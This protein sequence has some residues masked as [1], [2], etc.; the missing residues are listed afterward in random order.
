MT[1]LRKSI[2]LFHTV[3]YLKFIQIY[4]RVYYIFRRRLRK[5]FKFHYPLTLST[6]SYPL[7]L[8]ASIFNKSSVYIDGKNKI[9]SLLNINHTFVDC[10]DWDYSENGKLWLYNLAYF[11]YLQNNEIIQ[12]SC[13]EIMHDF[14]DNSQDTQ[15]AFDPYPISVRTVNWIKFI[16][17]NYIRDKKIDASLRAQYFILLDN[18]EY[19]LL[20]NHLLE[21]GFSLLFGSY[22]FRD[23][24]LYRIAKK[25]ITKELK[26]QVLRD[27]AHYE[28]SPMYHQIILFRILDCI[29][30]LS[31]NSYQDKELLPFLRKKAEL[32]LS[33]INNITFK[34]GDI[35]LFNDCAFGVSPNTQSLNKYAK[36]LKL[37]MNLNIKNLRESGYRK[38]VKPNYEMILDIGNLGPDYING[39]SH[40]DTFTFELHTDE[41]PIIVDTGISTYEKNDRRHLERSTKS[42]NTVL[43]DNIDQSQ[44]WSGF[45][46]ANR[47]KIIN[48]IDT[49]NSVEA[50]HD[51]YKKNGIFHTRKFVFN[52]NEI[53]I[54]DELS[55]SNYHNYST[56][57]HF[58]PS[59]SVKL[60]K[61]YLIINDIYIDF[62]GHN[63]IELSNFLYAPEFN[64]R[65]VGQCVNIKFNKSLV[66]RI[67]TDKKS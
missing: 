25:I 26:E 3:K 56:F 32:M 20:G 12:K 35:P 51:G 63:D 5:Y 21:N 23:G 67:C 2:L 41:K 52:D 55:S 39:H 15:N 16:T 8:Q 29:N 28:L 14:I 1:V 42:H 13:I 60:E 27:G 45:R 53:K 11:E 38:F 40:S 24:G 58:H 37:E 48:F 17:H 10:V 18:L 9:F 50:T 22:Y 57:L 33:W 36:S 4:Y 34:N 7:V 54:F 47:A 65:I 66:T 59:V 61:E 19:N 46:I 6:Y 44:I 49:N 43:V 31:N 64:K 62:K 30:L